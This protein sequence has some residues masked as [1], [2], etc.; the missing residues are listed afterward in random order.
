MNAETAL[1]H[2][3]MLALSD[4]GCLVFR[5]NTGVGYSGR[6]IDRQPHCVTVAT[7]RPITYGLCVG[8]AD[9]IGIAPGGKFL[10]FEIKTGRGRATT[11]QQ[12]FINAVLTAGGIAG[13]VR[14]PAEAVALLNM[15]QK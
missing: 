10:A 8:S 6:V 5:N 3:V 11:E 7:T 13:I 14:S 1:M 2:A 9:L 4:A 15:E 12:R